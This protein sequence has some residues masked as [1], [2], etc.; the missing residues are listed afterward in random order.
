[1]S[2][3]M[4]KCKITVVKR[5][6]NQDLIDEYL[7]IPQEHPGPCEYFSE[8]QEFIVEQ[9]WEPPEGFCAW[10]WADM[11]KDI[12]IAVGGGRFPGMKRSGIVITGCSDWFR[13]VIFKAEI[14]E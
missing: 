5:T 3:Q 1:M 8:G 2:S 10:A 14:M 6:I 13:T 4:P 7:E 11:R 9:V 12:L